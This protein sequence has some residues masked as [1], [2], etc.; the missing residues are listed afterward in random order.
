MSYV[1]TTQ[2]NNL[3]KAIEN[4]TLYTKDNV[5]IDAKNLESLKNIDLNKYSFVDFI[6]DLTYKAP[7]ITL[8]HNLSTLVYENGVTV[9]N[10][11]TITAKV[12]VGS[13]EIQQIEF[14][15]DGVS[16]SVITSD[17]ATGGN[18]NYADGTDIQFD[19]EYMAVIT[20]VN[21]KTYN[22]KLSIKFY[23]P[24]FYGVTRNVLNDVTDTEIL[25]LTK[26]VSNKG[27]KLYSFTN[28]N[29]YTLLAYPKEYGLLTSI[30]DSNKFEYISAF[31]HT[32]L[33][34]NSVIY[35]VYQQID[36]ST[37]N[38]FKFNFIF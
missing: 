31:N 29:E 12:V 35:Y 19:T 15:K 10:G 38:G 37:T 28:N 32:E 18:F 34:I 27:N 21:G 8:T 33:E 36:K 1:T 16:K 26:D 30:L 4:K 6:N 3:T 17:V 13:E 2:L 25:A 24:F 22:A 9:R 14:F 5:S 23:N 20:T 11:I 7:T